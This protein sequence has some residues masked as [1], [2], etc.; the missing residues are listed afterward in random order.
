M[1]SCDGIIRYADLRG[2]ATGFFASVAFCFLAALAFPDALPAFRATAL[3]SSGVMV[4]SL[5]FPPRF[6]IFARYSEMVDFL[7]T[8]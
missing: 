5:A 2:F 4:S 6:P 3:R 8:L 1:A 7:A